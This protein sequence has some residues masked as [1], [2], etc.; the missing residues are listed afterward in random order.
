ML[1]GLRQGAP[2]YVLNK[3]QFKVS[4]G[5]VVSVTPYSPKPGEFLQSFNMGYPQPRFVDIAAVVDGGNVN[6]SRINGDASVADQG[7]DGVFISETREAVL[8]EISAMRSASERALE[9]VDMHR[10][11]V[12]ECD[13]L[14]ME[15]NPELRREQEQS[16][17]IA[18]L[19]NDLN[20]MKNMLA[21]LLGAKKE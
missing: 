17:E 19:R 13:R 3:N 16:R 14:S 4:V 2:I 1:S 11:V 21:S 8:T 12:A 6:F 18:S 5:Q 10:K 9:Q 15:L 20:E 7:N